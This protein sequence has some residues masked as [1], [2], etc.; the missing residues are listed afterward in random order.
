MTAGPAPRGKKL[1][2]SRV[3]WYLSSLRSHSA[4]RRHALQIHRNYDARLPRLR[5]GC[6]R[7]ST[8]GGAKLGVGGNGDSLASTDR[9]RMDAAPEVCFVLRHKGGQSWSDASGAK[10][11]DE[12]RIFG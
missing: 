7:E 8:T 9:G 5:G 12:S 3:D 4:Y 2:S 11:D 1:P 10:S 6:L